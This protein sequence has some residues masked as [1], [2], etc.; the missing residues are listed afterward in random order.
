VQKLKE[1]EHQVFIFENAQDLLKD[2]VSDKKYKC[3]FVRCRKTFDN[4]VQ[5]LNHE[6][7]HVKKISC[8]RL[9][10]FIEN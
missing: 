6:E 8:S 3:F 2:S 1:K 5:L 9:D 4:I 7:I 10:F